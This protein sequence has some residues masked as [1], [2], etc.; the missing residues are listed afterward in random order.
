MSLARVADGR[1]GLGSAGAHRAAFPT[2][3]AWSTRLMTVAFPV[4]TYITSLVYKLHNSNLNQDKNG[5]IILIFNIPKRKVH[6]ANTY[7]RKAPTHISRTYCCRVSSQT[8]YVYDG[9]NHGIVTSSLLMLGKQKQEKLNEAVVVMNK[10]L[11]VCNC[12]PSCTYFRG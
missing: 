4:H 9:T 3:W 8:S 6:L 1:L 2:Y 7:N 12:D 10:S 11:Q 5:K